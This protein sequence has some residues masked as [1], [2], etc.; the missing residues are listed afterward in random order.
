MPKLHHILHSDMKLENNLYP[1]YLFVPL[2]LT[3]FSNIPKHFGVFLELA[4]TSVHIIR[5]NS[6][7]FR[8]ITG[9]SAAGDVAAQK[10]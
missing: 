4:I 9:V 10:K 8:R 2:D 6:V 3:T 1:R 5:K 7:D